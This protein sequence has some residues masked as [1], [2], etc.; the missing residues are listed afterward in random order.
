MDGVSL[1]SLPNND[2]PSGFANSSLGFGSQR[3]PSTLDHTPMEQFQPMMLYKMQQWSCVTREKNRSH[4]NTF[5]L[6]IASYQMHIA[7]TKCNH[8][9]AYAIASK[10]CKQLDGRLPFSSFQL[11][12]SWYLRVYEPTATLLQRQCQRRVNLIKL[13]ETCHKHDCTAFWCSRMLNDMISW[14]RD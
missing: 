11:I 1:P 5:S 14:M 10:S 4:M 12:Y 9:H 6:H 3:L 2:S 13:A 7:F 8:C